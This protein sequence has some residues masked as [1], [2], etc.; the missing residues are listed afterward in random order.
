MENLD[1]DIAVHN[2]WTKKNTE[3]V[4]KWKTVSKNLSLECTSLLHKYKNKVHKALIIALV[5]SSISTLLSGISGIS[6]ISNLV[7]TLY[8]PSYIN[9]ILHCIGIIINITAFVFSAIVAISSGIIK[10][11][12]WNTKVTDLTAFIKKIDVFYITVSNVLSLDDT[13]RPDAEEF[14]EKENAVYMNILESELE[15]SQL[16][17]D[18]E[19]HEK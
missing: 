19:L 8:I 17:L 18:N 1:S 11:Y 7:T 12:N 4:Q 2:N 15:I 3:I 13:L 9:I 14:I 10:I 5:F 6:G 16:Y